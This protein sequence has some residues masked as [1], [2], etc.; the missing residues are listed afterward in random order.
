MLRLF[1]SHAHPHFAAY[2]DDSDAVIRRALDAGIGMIAVGTKFETSRGAIASAERYDNVWAAVGLH[3]IHLASGYYDPNEDGGARTPAF[4]RAA[5]VFDEQ[6]WRALALSSSKV[7]AIGET[8]LDYYRLE[9]TTDEQEAA[10]RVQRDAFLAQA[11]LAGELQKT[12]I[13]HCREAH[14]DVYQVLTSVREVFPH[15]RIV[16]HC[17]TGTPTEGERYLRLGC[18]LSFP[19]IVTFAK[20]WDQFVAAV[21]KEQLL[22]E[23]D[24]PYLTPVPFRGKRNEPLFVEHTAA[25]IANLRGETIGA[26]SQQIVENSRQAFVI[27]Y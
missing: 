24:C 6:S 9:G 8:G 19:G 2:A 25:H 20:D 27:S 3:P 11:R 17:F 23:T 18:W 5:E 1:D 15:L 12:V 4:Q 10:K 26:F 21:P 14:D 13:V 7:V 16:M 22:I